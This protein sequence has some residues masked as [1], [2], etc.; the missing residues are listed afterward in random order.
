MIKNQIVIRVDETSF[1][2]LLI[3]V[4]CFHTQLSDAHSFKHFYESLLIRIY[5]ILSEFLN[6]IIKK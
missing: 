6:N 1:C 4:Y 3:I 5:D 2:K